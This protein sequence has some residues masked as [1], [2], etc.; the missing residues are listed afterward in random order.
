M[1][2]L[3]V[4]FIGY[5]YWLKFI[6]CKWLRSDPLKKSKILISEGCKRA[7][8]SPERKKHIEEGRH[9][10]KAIADT[11]KPRWP[12]RLVSSQ[13]YQECLYKVSYAVLNM[14]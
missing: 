7:V 12:G 5:K 14:N 3:R 8:K 9:G 2:M 4:S 13:L 10:K 6:S 1:A 11:V